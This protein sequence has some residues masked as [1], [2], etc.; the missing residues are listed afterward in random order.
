[1]NIRT[2][3]LTNLTN[4]PANDER[5]EL[6]PDGRLLVFSSNRKEPSDPDLY[7]FNLETNEIKNIT[8]SEGYDLI[9]RWSKDG[10]SIVYGSNRSG[11]WEIYRYDIVDGLSTRLTNNSAFNGDPRV[12]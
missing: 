3:E 1:M 7:I 2:K 4:H 11:N 8:N 9:G 10:F 6:S 5:G 12:R